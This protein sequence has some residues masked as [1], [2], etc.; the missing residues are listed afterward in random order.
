MGMYI[1]IYQLHEASSCYLFP[2]PGGLPLRLFPE[3][4]VEDEKMAV[5][6]S[7]NRLWGVE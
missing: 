6:E 4:G 7:E 3:D 5:M 2:Q 1:S